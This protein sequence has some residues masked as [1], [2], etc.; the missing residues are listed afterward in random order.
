LPNTSFTWGINSY[1]GNQADRRYPQ[2][3]GSAT[4]GPVTANPAGGF[5]WTFEASFP[6]EALEETPA[7][8]LAR[9]GIFGFGVAYNDDD[10]RE[11]RDAQPVWA[12]TRDDLWHVSAAFPDAQLVD[13]PAPL[14]GDYNS[15]GTVDAADYVAWR[16]NPG[17]FGGDP[18]GYTTWRTNF[19]RTGGAGSALS[20]AAAAVPEPA[21]LALLLLLASTWLFRRRR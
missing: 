18:A 20:G 9:D 5:D 3:M 17:A 8:I 11:G 13:A 6:W 12:T 15:N 19:G 14:Q 2:N 21:T 1:D 4:S 10:D 7:D 16:D